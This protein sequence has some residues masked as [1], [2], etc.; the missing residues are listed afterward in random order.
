MTHLYH[1]I[2]DELDHIRWK[3]GEDLWLIFGMIGVMLVIA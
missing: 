3:Y 2:A 1:A